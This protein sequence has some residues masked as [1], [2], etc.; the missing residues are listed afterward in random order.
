MKELLKVA[1][2]KMYNALNVYYQSICTVINAQFDGVLE[3]GEEGCAQYLDDGGEQFIT[4]I[5]V[6][7]NELCITLGNDKKDSFIICDFNIMTLM[8]IEEELKRQLL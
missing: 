2:D 4:K 7:D 6:I 5:E 1:H 3:L 8:S